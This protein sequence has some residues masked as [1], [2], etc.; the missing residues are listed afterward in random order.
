MNDCCE[1]NAKCR[2]GVGSNMPGYMPD[3]HVE[4]FANYSD[5]LKAYLGSVEQAIIDDGEAYEGGTGLEYDEL[6][7]TFGLHAD[8]LKGRLARKRTK[9]T[10]AAFR[11]GDYVHWLAR[12]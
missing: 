10:E 9:Y 5:A 12:I 4:H 2:W 6:V 8:L 3:S 1:H 11:V 7:L